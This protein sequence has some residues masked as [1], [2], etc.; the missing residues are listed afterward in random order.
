MPIGGRLGGCDLRVTTRLLY[1]APVGD[2]N[3]AEER[4]ALETLVGGDRAEREAWLLAISTLRYFILIS[5]EEPAGHRRTDG[6]TC[7][8]PL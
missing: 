3:H 7:P 1:Y 6:I 2:E 4:C 8:S 5:P